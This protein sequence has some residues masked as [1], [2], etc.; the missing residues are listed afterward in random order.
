MVF[1]FYFIAK[2]EL[3]RSLYFSFRP[4]RENHAIDFMA[5]TSKTRETETQEVFDK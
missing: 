3:N 5:N 2:E 1:E 4:C